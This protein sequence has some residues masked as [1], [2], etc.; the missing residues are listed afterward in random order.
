MWMVIATMQFKMASLYKTSIA[1][2]T[3]VQKTGRMSVDGRTVRRNVGRGAGRR[4][5]HGGAAGRT[6]RRKLMVEKTLMMI[7][8]GQGSL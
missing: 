6:S 5:A 1:S 7:R 3:N 2:T 4:S 8:S